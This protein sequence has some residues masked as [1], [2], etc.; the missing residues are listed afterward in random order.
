MSPAALR[1]AVIAGA[2]GLDLIV[3]ARQIESA[4]A[5]AACFERAKYELISCAAPPSEWAFILP[6]ALLIVLS[7]FLGLE[8]GRRARI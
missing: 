7:V 1:R 3:V 6:A 8:L 4:I 5:S 2:I